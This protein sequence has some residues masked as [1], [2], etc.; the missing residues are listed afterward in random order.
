MAV[1]VD[2]T[3]CDAE[4]VVRGLLEV[5]FVVRSGAYTSPKFGKKFVN[6]NVYSP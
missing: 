3:G 5:G 4:Q 6:Y 1:D 2:G